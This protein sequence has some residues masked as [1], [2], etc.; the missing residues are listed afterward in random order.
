MAMKITSNFQ[1]TR[2][3]KIS[4][5]QEMQGISLDL[6][7]FKR[8]KKGVFFT[9]DSILA[10]GIVLIVIIFASSSYIREQPSFHLNY[11][12]QDLIKTL[13]TLTVGEID[14]EYLN[15]LSSSEV[16]KDNTILEQIAEFWAGSDLEK[17]NKTASNVTGLFVPANMGF[18]IWIDG[19]AIYTRDM[20]I[21]KSLV[22]SKKIISGVEKGKTSGLT[23]KNPP[24]LLGPAIVEA[25]VWQ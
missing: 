9:I 7:K 19:E 21:K 3:S 6:N 4:G 10:A 11:L 24:T 18:G 20:L 8:I 14:N 15:S 1:G 5:I 16:D 17:A 2:K 25:R 13:S 12:S 23:R 22:S